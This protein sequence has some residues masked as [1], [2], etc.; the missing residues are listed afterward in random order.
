[1]LHI[2]VGYSIYII[3]CDYTLTLTLKYECMLTLVI[4][5]LKQPQIYAMFT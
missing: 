1:M 4:K 5:I 3:C 2:A